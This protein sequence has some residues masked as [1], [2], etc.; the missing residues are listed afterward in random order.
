VDNIQKAI[1]HVFS[2]LIIS[3]LTNNTFAGNNI[4]DA[5]G[6]TYYELATYEDSGTIEITYD[7][8]YV[9]KSDYETLFKR[10]V[11]LILKIKHHERNGDISDYIVWGDGKQGRSYRKIG[12][13]E[14]LDK[15]SDMAL[16]LDDI[17]RIFCPG[18]TTAPSFLLHKKQPSGSDYLLKLG[19]AG[20]ESVTHDVNERDP[21]FVV[22]TVE[23]ENGYKT[24][25]WIDRIS[26]LIKTIDIHSPLKYSTWTECEVKINEVKI[27]YPLSDSEFRFEPMLAQRI[28]GPVL[29]PIVKFFY[30]VAAMIS[31]GH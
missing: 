16:R 11:G 4:L 6:G 19:F 28:I 31:G 1:K 29:G 24:M 27:N 14:V 12:D 22:S 15:E 21:A 26:G 5:V 18:I 3:A 20:H 17:G 8:G 13:T 7:D 30:A 9:G 10:G 25:Y 2:V 23:V